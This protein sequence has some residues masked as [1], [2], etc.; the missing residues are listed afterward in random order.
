MSRRWVVLISLL[1][2]SSC[3]VSSSPPPISWDDLKARASQFDGKSISICGWFEAKL[4]LCSLAP[5]EG[6]VGTAGTI[7]VVPVGHWCTFDQQSVYP[8][9]GWAL[10][11]GVFHYGGAYGHFGAWD[12]GLGHAK[13]LMDDERC[14][15]PQKFPG[16]VPEHP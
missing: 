16:K 11:S 7:W 5:M 1:V 12:M 13:V 4:E 8:Y 3:A 10:I 6:S 9:E 15:G 2:A 14:K